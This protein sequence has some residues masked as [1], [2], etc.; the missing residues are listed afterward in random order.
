MIS[1]KKILFENQE[2]TEIPEGIET[3]DDYLDEFYYVP[4]EKLLS[5][6]VDVEKQKKP[7]FW[8]SKIEFNNPSKVVY[9]YNIKKETNDFGRLKPRYVLEL[10][11]NGFDRTEASD[12][13]NDI[14]TY[15]RA[16]EYFNVDFEQKTNDDFWE[17]PSTLYHATDSQENLDSILENGLE[18]RSESR[19][20]TNKFV[21]NAVFTSVDPESIQDYAGSDGGIVSIDTNMMKQNGYTPF[22][23]VEPEVLEKEVASALANKLGIDY[24]QEYLDSGM[25]P[26][27]FIVHGDIPAKYIK[28]YEG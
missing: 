27:T 16:H 19:G 9:V 10:G 28:R 24:E 13:L 17:Y 6:L 11:D 18:E 7:N 21:G 2:S 3:I 20:I 12:W 8:I 5:K 23:G 25:D 1:L 15:D 26:N 14:I 22:V 4:N